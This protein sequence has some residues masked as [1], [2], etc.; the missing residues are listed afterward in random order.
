MTSCATCYE[1]D[2]RTNIV[3]LFLYLGLNQLIF[4]VHS[5]NNGRHR[6]PG[7]DI[8]GGGGEFRPPRVPPTRRYSL[9]GDI[10]PAD[11]RRYAAL[12]AD[13]VPHRMDH[14]ELLWVG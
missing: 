11:D 8:P 4:L 5:K 9:D 12:I 13:R 1:F 3:W 2:P 6:P 10:L 14:I 7:G